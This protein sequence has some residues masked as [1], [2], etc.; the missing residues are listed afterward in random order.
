MI[1]KSYI[2]EKNISVLSN[3]FITM[4]YGE[5][6]GL[7]DEIKKKLKEKYQN[8]E[9]VMLNQDEIIKNVDV[10]NNHILN[11]RKTRRWR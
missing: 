11:S 3:Y 1:L 8:S 7:K 10:L 6:I 5:N 4:I 9:Q 2:V